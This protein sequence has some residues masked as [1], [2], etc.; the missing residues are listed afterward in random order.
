[1]NPMSA[2]AVSS[3]LVLGSG[4]M[5]Y[6]TQAGS[7]AMNS[8]Q[9]MTV[10]R[11]GAQPSSAGPAEYFTGSVRVEP[12]FPAHEPRSR[13]AAA[14]VTFQPGARSA[15]HTH[16]L[17]QNLI[18]TAGRGWVQQEGGEKHEIRPGDVV[19]TPPGVKH[20]HGATPN[21]SLTHYAIQEALHG[22]NVE[23]M[24]KVTDQQ[25][26]GGK[27]IA[28]TPATSTPRMSADDDLAAVA[29]A[30]ARYRQDVL[31]GDLWKRPGLSSRDRRIVTVTAL[32][33]RNQTADLA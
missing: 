24:E 7:Q 23:W 22:K 12:T 21:E 13:V 4:G 2:A 5:S 19:W 10:T 28:A 15:W 14:L 1:M 29:P 30:L 3:L 33:A 31:V 27:V 17:G 8:A 9:T 20:W 11:K 6:A 16:P 25:Y 32:I 26:L 18:V